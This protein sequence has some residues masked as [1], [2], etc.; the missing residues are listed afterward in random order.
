MDAEFSTGQTSRL[1]HVSQARVL[2]WCTERLIECSVTPGGHYRI[3]QRAIS[4]V[5]RNAATRASAPAGPRHWSPGDPG[6]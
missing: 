2:R 6:D 4:A 5:E 3:P 1:L